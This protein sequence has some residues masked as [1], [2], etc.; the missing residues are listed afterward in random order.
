[1]EAVTGLAVFNYK[2]SSPPA[3]PIWAT[4][5][6][7]VLHPASSRVVA[8]PILRFGELQDDTI[9]A[10]AA[11]S[12]SDTA[13]A[14]R[15]PQR[16]SHHQ[17][18]PTDRQQERAESSTPVSTKAMGQLRVAALY[19]M[20]DSTQARASVKVDGSLVIAFLWDGHFM[21]ATRRRMDSEQV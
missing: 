4:C 1:M 16:S 9:A 7:L 10:A 11:A 3:N 6:G 5:R 12:S 13:A 15:V 21:A 19:S 14:E 20:L 2:L 17:P 18:F 8:M